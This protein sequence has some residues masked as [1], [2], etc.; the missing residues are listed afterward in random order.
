[1]SQRTPIP[2]AQT[3]FLT[4]SGRV[5]E[6]WRQYLLALGDQDGNAGPDLGPIFIA[7]AEI[8]QQDSAFVPTSY[9]S[10]SFIQ[11]HDAAVQVFA[12]DFIDVHEAIVP[13]FFDVAS[14][15]DAG[16]MSAD[17]KAKLDGIS[18]SGVIEDIFVAG[19]GFTPGTTTSLTLS[20]AYAS[21][22]AVLVHF[23]GTFQGSDQ[24]SISGNTITFTSPIPTGIS[25]VYAR[26]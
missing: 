17:D 24:Y 25:T 23:D 19:P 1:M 15:M 9:E 10:T 6:P 21:S 3:A 4:A 5:S 2:L 12:R 14:S 11:S 16:L 8:R 20:K 13:K 7:L 18:T 26:G 22:A